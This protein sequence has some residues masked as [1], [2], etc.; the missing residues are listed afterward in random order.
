[1][2]AATVSTTSS[3]LCVIPGNSYGVIIQNEGTT[4]IRIN[5][6]REASLTGLNKGLVIPPAVD[7]VPSEWRLDFEAGSSIG[8]VE[9]HAIAGVV[10]SDITYVLQTYM[11]R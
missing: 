1:M 10:N 5:I 7:D 8:D 9:I 2:P 6:N 11:L 3:I 4:P